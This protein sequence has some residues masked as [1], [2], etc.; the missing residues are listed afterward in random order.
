MRT[1]TRSQRDPVD[2]ASLMSL[3]NVSRQDAIRTMSDLSRRVGSTSS[4]RSTKSHGKSGNARKRKSSALPGK[5]REQGHGRDAAT[6]GDK[7]NMDLHSKSHSNLRENRLSV[8]TVSSGSTK[9]GEVRRE[10]S[11]EQRDDAYNSSRVMYPLHP[12]S[13]QKP[14]K[15]KKWWGLFSR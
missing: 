15:P 14:Q 5:K 9:L 11:R 3:S 1:V 8:L 12:H 7:H 10:R 13:S 2:Y 4:S 6:G